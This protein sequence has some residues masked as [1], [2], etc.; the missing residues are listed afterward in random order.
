VAIGLFDSPWQ[1]VDLYAYY[2]LAGR[3]SVRL[4]NISDLIGPVKVT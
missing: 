4:L 2:G 1:A 3:G